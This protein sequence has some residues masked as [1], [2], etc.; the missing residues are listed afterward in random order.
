M[1]KQILIL[2]E[3]RLAA[4]NLRAR[5]AAFG[6][7][8]VAQDPKQLEAALRAEADLVVC[9]ARFGALAG[10]ALYQRLRAAERPVYLYSDEAEAVEA[11]DWREQGLREAFTRLQRSNLVLAVEQAL[12]GAGGASAPAFLLVED[13]PTVRQFVKAVLRQAYPGAEVIEAE[14]GRS[15]LA[16]MKSSRIS[17]IVTDL[18]MPGMDGLSFVQLLRN[19]AVLK[20]KPVLVLSGAVSEEARE[21]LK[22]LAKVQV[23]AKPASP[24]AL[25]EA[26]KSLLS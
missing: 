3:D 12:Q 16:A 11:D 26:V 5:L 20:K 24:E 19:N 13:S 8:Q 18:Q 1:A 6:D 15:A 4:E 2:D 21:N 25:V 9:G 7:V 10:A 22:S 23:L 14:D 17:L